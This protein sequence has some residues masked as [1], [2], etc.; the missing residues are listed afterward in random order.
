MVSQ[1]TSLRTRSRS[2]VRVLFLKPGVFLVQGGGNPYEGSG[3]LT[4]ASVGS[5]RAFEQSF[6]GPPTS[7]RNYSQLPGLM[8]RKSQTG[9]WRAPVYAPKW[10]A[11]STMAPIEPDGILDLSRD[12]GSLPWARLRRV[13]GLRLLCAVDR[14]NRLPV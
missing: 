2:L 12:C 9:S 14:R 1:M 8:P 7:A 5:Q 13:P 6:M 4:T 10:K 3:S 11:T